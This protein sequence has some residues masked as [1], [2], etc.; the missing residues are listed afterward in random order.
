MA[1][2]LTPEAVSSKQDYLQQHAEVP[3]TK[4]SGMRPQ[5]GSAYRKRRW[6]F[7]TAAA[8]FVIALITVALALDLVQIDQLMVWKQEAAE[9]PLV[10]A[11]KASSKSARMAKKPFL[12]LKVNV[13]LMLE[14]LK[15]RTP[16]E[17]KNLRYTMTVSTLESLQ[18]QRMEFYLY[19][20]PVHITLP[21]AL[22]RGGEGAKLKSFLGGSG[23]LQPFLELQKNGSYKV[24][25]EAITDAEKNKVPVDLYRLWL[26]DDEAVLVPRS[27]FKTGVQAKAA[28]KKSQVAGFAASLESDE[29]LAVLAIHL[30]KDLGKEWTEKIQQ[31]PSVKG[32][33]QA[34]MIAGMGG[35]FFSEMAEPLQQIESLAMAFRF[36]KE[37]E[38]TLRYAQQFRQ[39]V[40]GDKVYQELT[41]E[42]RDEFEDESIITNMV[43]VLQDKR[44]DSK[45][46]HEDNLLTL[47]F[48]WQ[49][50]HD[51]ELGTALSQ[52][53]IGYMFAHAMEM[54]P[55]AGG[56]DTEY[57]DEPE[58]VA[59][60]DFSKFK[61]EIPKRFRQRLFPGHYWDFGDEPYMKVV[62][63]RVDMPN[64]A[65]A[66]L[67]YDVM[68]VTSPDGKSVLRQGKDPF[69]QPIRPGDPNPG[70]LSLLVKKETSGEALGKAK[71]NFNLTFPVELATVEFKADESVGT[72][73][74]ADGVRVKLRQLEKDVAKVAYR[75]GESCLLIAYDKT[76][77]PLASKA[78]SYGPMKA[79]VRFKGVVDRLKVVLGKEVVTH[80]FE[81]VVNLNK[82][83]ELK[84]ANKPDSSVRVRYDSRLA[85]TY[86][87][88]SDQELN[89][90]QVKWIEGGNAGFSDVLRLSL[91]KGP[92]SGEAHWETHLYGKD[93]PI[94]IEGSGSRGGRDFTYNTYEPKLG[95]ANAAFGRVKLQV[96]ADIHRLSF[97]KKK[98]GEP[99]QQKLPSGQRVTVLFNKN[100]ISF[101]VG[102]LKIIQF[103]AYDADGKRLM[104]GRS[105]SSNGGKMEAYF[106]GQPA[107][108]V[109]DTAG[110]SI[111][112]LIVF[113]IKHRG[114][115]Q[116]AYDSYRKDIAKHREVVKTLKAIA[117]ARKRDY[118]FNYGDDLAGLYY[119]NNRHN[120]PRKM[121][122]QTVA[123][124]DPAGQKRFGYKVKPYK[125]YYFTVFSGI[126]EEGKQKAYTR[127]S[128]EKTYTWEKGSITTKPLNTQPDIVAIPTDKNQPTFYIEWDRVYM[129]YLNGTKLRYK[130]N[131]YTSAGWVTAD[132]IDA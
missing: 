98:D 88:Y 84:L 115:D 48:N 122:N 132:F 44:F 74:Q 45:I 75:G 130:P 33:N 40:D 51:K 124:S 59:S 83:E 22:L 49:E 11:K 85:R 60:L 65:M 1:E 93:K 106:W 56:V 95:Q 109:V 39:T 125:G 23:P 50:K 30:P 81:L 19:P 61:S 114:V 3:S 92:V 5:D 67:S 64:I 102:K 76:G 63:D 53:T 103:M 119:L 99:L 17:Q 89:G 94:L 36:K 77:R 21:V 46:V 110:K 25:K 15:K 9:K 71:V 87:S 127:Q 41:K 118:F 69:K 38:R 126:E 10:A 116:K 91:P 58:L 26:V 101:N 24:K 104:K 72:I 123:H 68:D 35:A 8:A 86:A 54:K 18:L 128:Q 62:C 14:A 34:K 66:S 7:L 28:I 12:C 129:K 96:D 82:G 37:K 131:H 31:H 97:V 27:L 90:L 42:T 78:N 4:A 20:D 111:N 43:K 112:K 121:I 16:E 100:K 120:K 32:N 47:E 57:A 70:E 107:K 52:A 2:K 117:R 80:Q 79:S 105:G 55:S 13:P 29:D 73:K 6:M 113:N 108:F